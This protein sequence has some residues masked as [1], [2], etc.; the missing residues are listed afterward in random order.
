MVVMKM[1]IVAVALLLFRLLMRRLST[2]QSQY[3][4]QLP[5]KKRV[6]ELVPWCWGDRVVVSVAVAWPLFQP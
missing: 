4:Q 5:M 2:W 3:W 1:M 6:V